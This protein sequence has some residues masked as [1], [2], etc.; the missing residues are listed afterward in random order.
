ME[1]APAQPAADGQVVTST[2]AALA[3]GCVAAR[4]GPKP[5]VDET[6]EQAWL[7]RHKDLGICIAPIVCRLLRMRKRHLDDMLGDEPCL[8]LVASNHIAHDQ[9]IG[10]V[11]AA[12]RREAR[13]RSCFLEDDFMRV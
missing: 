8:Q 10:S 11:I 5:G 3:A 4:A 1:K 13:H 7:A 12:A 9:I 6:T 2:A